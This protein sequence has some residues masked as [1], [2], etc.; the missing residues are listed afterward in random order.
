[1]NH[2]DWNAHTQNLRSLLFDSSS[3][4]LPDWLS[5]QARNAAKRYAGLCTT[6]EFQTALNGISQRGS[7]PFEIFVV[8]EGDFGKSTLV[9]ALLGE[10]VAKVHILPETRTFHRLILSRN[11]SQTARLM[12]HL[13][14][15]HHEWL[16]KEIGV[17]KPAQGFFEVMEHKVP[18]EVARRLVA[19]EAERAKKTKDGYELA[20]FEIEQEIRWTPSSPFPERVRIVDT[21]GLNQQLPGNMLPFIMANDGKNTGEKVVN[22][23]NQ[24]VRGRHM[25]W[26]YRRCDAVLWLLRAN[27]IQSA[28]TKAL[29]DVFSAYGKKTLLV[30][31][32]IDESPHDRPRILQVAEE[33]YRNRVDGIL[34]VNGKLALQ[35]ALK[36]ASEMSKAREMEDASGLS[37]LRAQIHDLCVVRGLQTKA[38]G[39]Y[40][41]LRATESD[42]RN[43]LALFLGRLSET[44]RQL[45]GHKECVRKIA[46]DSVPLLESE[47]AAATKA[48]KEKLDHN[49]CSITFWDDGPSA[50][51]K[52]AFNSLCTSYQENANKALKK[53]EAEILKVVDQ[54]QEA[55]YALPV[56]DPLGNQ[57]GESV[58]V[59]AAVSLRQ[60]PLKV[61]D[62][63]IEL[64]RSFWNG[65]GEVFSWFTDLFRSEAGKAAKERE[66]Q[67]QLDQIHQKVHAQCDPRLNSLVTE[68]ETK[69]K[70]ELKQGIK[71]ID[72]AIGRVEERLSSVEHEP[73]TQTRS[74]LEAM[75]AETAM[76][77][78]VGSQCVSAFKALARRHQSA[79]LAAQNR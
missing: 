43:A 51:R 40:S 76:K 58:S 13:D 24:H 22:R 25:L 29:F 17:G 6:P 53:G 65:V 61:E 73:L 55:P 38:I 37:A 66:R 7:E 36:R 32:R 46:V 34:P 3:G 77:S 45:E 10:E 21:Q 8:G 78:A 71:S 31:T 11:P 2:A 26:Q 28:A 75:L 44:I 62:I 4:R 50:D 59:K 42:L 33:L 1:M 49:V 20:I 47:L 60:M 30:V 56:F 72:G 54:L 57:S 23:L 35:G 67:E 79:K 15:K 27:K 63:H 5:Q 70:K 16:R 18:V 68:C 69:I 19:E 48:A 64:D 9:N 52:V 41:S 74:R 12:V 14:P 39:L